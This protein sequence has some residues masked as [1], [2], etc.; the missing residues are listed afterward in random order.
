MSYYQ[1]NTKGKKTVIR[2]DSENRVRRFFPRAKRISA[3]QA[4]NHE[5]NGGAIQNIVG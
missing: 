3:R 2:S 1:E 5:R 4:L